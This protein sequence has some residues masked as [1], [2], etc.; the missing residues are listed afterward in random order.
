[1][2]KGKGQKDKDGLVLATRRIIKNGASFYVSI[3]P[4]FMKRHSLKKG[5]SVPV[6]ADSILKIIPMKE[7][8]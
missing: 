8:E 5:D 6:I 4:E 7:I 3:P 2:R 1:M